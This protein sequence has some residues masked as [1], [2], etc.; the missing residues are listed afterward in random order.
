MRENKFT[1]MQWSLIFFALWT[2]KSQNNFRRLLKY[3]YALL[4]NP[5]IPVKKVFMGTVFYFS[6]SQGP[7]LRTYAIM[8]QNSKLLK[9]KTRKVF[10]TLKYF[11][12]AIIY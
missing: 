5:L 11:Y 3:Y 8:R 1:L 9:E 6:D 7:R 2:H 10:I 4:A 12:E